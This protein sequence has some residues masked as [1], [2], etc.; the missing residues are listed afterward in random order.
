M[1]VV[2]VVVIC[3]QSWSFVVVVVVVVCGSWGTFVVEVVVAV[4]CD[5]GCL[6]LSLSDCVR[7]GRQRFAASIAVPTVVEDRCG[8]VM[9][10]GAFSY[11][12]CKHIGYMG[13]WSAWVCPQ[14]VGGG[15]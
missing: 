11:V 12:L 3:R 15:V 8:V 13:G 4:V 9:V 14:V 6:L 2:L 5:G 7:D 10:P 1:V